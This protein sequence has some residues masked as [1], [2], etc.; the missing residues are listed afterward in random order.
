MKSILAT[1]ET[2]IIAEVLDDMREAFEFE[3]IHVVRMIE[4]HGVS[5]ALSWNVADATL[6]KHEGLKNIEKTQS[7]PVVKWK[8]TGGPKQQRPI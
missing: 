3:R 7:R 5:T 6:V 4:R 8:W 2:K 1:I